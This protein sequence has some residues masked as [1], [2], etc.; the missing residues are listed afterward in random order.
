MN[1]VVYEKPVAEILEFK[2]EESIASSGDL[3]PG[4]ICTEEY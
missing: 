4:T 1:K 3:G 2:I